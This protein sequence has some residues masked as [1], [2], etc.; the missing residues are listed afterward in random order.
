LPRRKI[1]HAAASGMAAASLSSAAKSSSAM[2]KRSC[3]VH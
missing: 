3:S 1:L 2:A